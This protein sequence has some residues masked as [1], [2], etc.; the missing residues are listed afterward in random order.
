MCGIWKVLKESMNITQMDQELLG[1]FG[2]AKSI[3]SGVVEALS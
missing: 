1:A 2:G 3:D